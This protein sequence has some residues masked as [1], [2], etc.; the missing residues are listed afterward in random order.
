MLRVFVNLISKEENKLV[1]L[2]HMQF[3][4]QSKNNHYRR[5]F[6]SSKVTRHWDVWGKLY[7]FCILTCYTIKLGKLWCS[8]LSLICYWFKFMAFFP[9]RH[10]ENLDALLI[11]ELYLLISNAIVNPNW[12]TTA[13]SQDN[14]FCNA[15]GI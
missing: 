14:F 15:L 11:R 4:K 8:V 7:L 10:Q 5:N 1:C 3:N 13:S 6:V 12:S 9:Y 2:Y